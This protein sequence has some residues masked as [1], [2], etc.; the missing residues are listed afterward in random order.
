MHA[1]KN[2]TDQVVL[3]RLNSGIEIN[4]APRGILNDVAESEIRG[5]A[6][7][8]KLRSLNMVEIG[9]AEAARK[10]TSASVDHDRRQPSVDADEPS[11]K[12]PVHEPGP[13]DRGDPNFKQ[14]K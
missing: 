12:R 4:V 11:P 10:K 2:L 13:K 14:K 3:I 7:L 5:N 9:D 6:T 1:V 8:G